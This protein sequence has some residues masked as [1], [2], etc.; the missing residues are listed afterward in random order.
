MRGRER[1]RE[2]VPESV[3]CN[4]IQTGAGLVQSPLWAA[5]SSRVD[6]EY[7]ERREG[8]GRAGL[9]ASPLQHFTEL[10]D[11]PT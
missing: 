8:G 1:E 10:N 9:W 5:L 7:R 11:N 2:R 3:V 4:L 6:Y